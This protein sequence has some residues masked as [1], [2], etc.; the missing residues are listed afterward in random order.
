MKWRVVINEIPT[1]SVD[2]MIVELDTTGSMRFSF[3]FF[4]FTDII[5]DLDTLSM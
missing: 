1:P 2:V 3:R 4:F 5:M